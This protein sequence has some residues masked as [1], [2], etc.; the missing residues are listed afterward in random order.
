MD[1]GLDRRRTLKQVMV[2]YPK[3]RVDLDNRGLYAYNSPPPVAP[4]RRLSVLAKRHS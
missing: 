2:R 4:Q 3:A 1:P